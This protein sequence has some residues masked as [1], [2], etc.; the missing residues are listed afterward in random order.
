MNFRLTLPRVKTYRSS[1][2]EREIS[3]IITKAPFRHDNVINLIMKIT[4]R[5]IF[6]T[7]FRCQI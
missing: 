7:T 3:F 1:V 4:G 6:K 5:I 2:T